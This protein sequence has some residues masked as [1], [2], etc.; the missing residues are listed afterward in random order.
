MK[1]ELEFSLA[2]SP[3]AL[4]LS[5]SALEENRKLVI[6]YTTANEAFVLLY[7]RK[8]PLFLRPSIPPSI[9]SAFCFCTVMGRMCSR[10]LV[11]YSDDCLF[12]NVCQSRVLTGQDNESLSSE[13]KRFMFA[14][15]RRIFVFS[16]LCAA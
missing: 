10:L 2:F 7:Q 6:L 8:M 15:I 5:S 13:L 3:F 1:D 11:F 14:L 9:C 4:S 12:L 16:E